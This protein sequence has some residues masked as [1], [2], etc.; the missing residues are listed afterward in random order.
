MAY[1]TSWTKTAKTD[2]FQIMDI[3][4]EDW[5]KKSARN[6]R[7]TVTKQI[8]LISKMPKMYPKTEVREDV[9]RCVISKQVSLYYLVNQNDKEIILLRFYD[10]RKEIRDLTEMLNP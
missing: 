1:K 9:R 8:N 6:F 4:L 2:Y 7:D 3:L 10:N 5:G